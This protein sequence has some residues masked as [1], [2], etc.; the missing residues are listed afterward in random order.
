VGD[1][2]KFS[3]SADNNPKGYTIG[4]DK[5]GTRIITKDVNNPFSISTLE[6]GSYSAYVTSWND[7]GGNDSNR[8]YF[9]VNP[10]QPKLSSVS[11]KSKPSKLIYTV[12]E[13]L[14]T[15]GLKLTAAYSDNSTKEISSGFT[16]T[17]IILNTAGTQKITVTYNGK[18][19]S[20]DVTVNPAIVDTNALKI[21]VSSANAKA[22]DEV[23]VIISLA[24]NPGFNYMKLKVKYDKNAMSLSSTESLNLLDSFS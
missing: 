13:T 10:K 5:D 24:D 14:A 1:T 9:T 11:I 7:Y 19:T 4:I 12:G 8:V 17:P 2:V 22:G 23:S 6:A 21:N 18:T 15:S 16:Y 20:F 3:F